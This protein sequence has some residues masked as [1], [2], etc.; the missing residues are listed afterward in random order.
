MS[1]ATQDAVADAHQLNDGSPTKIA[2]SELVKAHFCFTLQELQNFLKS[3]KSA[4]ARVDA[5]K[6][7]AQGG[8]YE[9]FTTSG[10]AGPRGKQGILARNQESNKA[11]VPVSLTR[12]FKSSLTQQPS[13]LLRCQQTKVYPALWQVLSDVIKEK[14]EKKR[15]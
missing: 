11:E 14:A 8:S 3:A 12:L 6:M 9:L 7:K 2:K 10:R 5:N 13:N 15:R 4:V 1:E